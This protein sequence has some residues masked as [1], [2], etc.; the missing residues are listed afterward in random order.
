MSSS[1]CAETP[2]QA[3]GKWFNPTHWSVVLAAGHGM[4]PR[5]VEAREALCKTYWEPIYGYVRRQGYNVPDAQDLTQGFFLHLLKGNRLADL[6]PKNG[7]FRSFLLTVL[8]HFLADQ[9]DHACTAKRGG[10]QPFLSEDEL[11]IENRYCR[12]AAA[13]LSAEAIYD[14]QWALALLDQAVTR[15]WRRFA[16]TGKSDQFEHLKSFLSREGSGQDYAN[17]ARALQSSPGAVAVSVHRMRTQYRELVKDEI[18]KTVSS[19]AEVEEEFRYLLEVL[20]Q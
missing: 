8:R 20:S 18:G 11:A 15:L 16:E 12:C 13:S 6:D 4:S 19:A 2:A 14:R 17:A 1:Q 3:E 5:S 10:G 9:N 7:K